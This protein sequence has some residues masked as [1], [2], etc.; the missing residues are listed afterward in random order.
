MQLT[1]Y[2]SLVL[3]KV[4]IIL[5]MVL[6]PFGM[7]ACPLQYM[8]KS[9]LLGGSLSNNCPM[10]RRAQWL[11]AKPVRDEPQLRLMPYCSHLSGET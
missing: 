4:G 5:R 11:A 7:T 10:A 9:A 1:C 3:R 6:I 8:N 2:S